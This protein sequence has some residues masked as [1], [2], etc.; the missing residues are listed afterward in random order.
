MYCIG[1]DGGG[2]HSRLAGIDTEMNVLG[3]QAGGSTNMASGTYE[4]VYENIAK[5]L[6]GFNAETNTLPTECQGICIGSAGVSVGDNAMLLEKMF[7]EAGFTCKVKVITDAE[8]VLAAE[9][10]GEPGVAIISGTGSIGYAIDKSGN[11]LRAGGWG[12]IIDDGGSGYR[13]GM[14]AIQAALM[15]FDGRGEKT[16]LTK[17]ILEHFQLEKPSD[18][19]TLVYGANFNKSKIGEAAMLVKDASANGDIVAAK[20]EWQAS[21]S[22]F[23]LAQALIKRAELDAHKLV[24]SGSIITHNENIRSR[25]C[26]AIA[27]DFPGMLI[28]PSSTKPELGAAY[29]AARG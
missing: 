3:Y 22:L 15:D 16:I 10:K 13:I 17:M 28:T 14:D 7:R 11:T 24:I 4:S 26:K 8:L 27:E 18:I 25:F 1:I 2:T 9:T 5:L 19:L 20:I 29:L 21:N 23:G 6:K 12:H